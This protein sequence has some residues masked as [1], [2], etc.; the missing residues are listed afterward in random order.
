M[1]DDKGRFK[2]EDDLITMNLSL[3]SLTKI[4]FLSLFFVVFFP[5]IVIISKLEL[6][7]RIFSFFESV[8]TKAIGDPE[9]NKKNGLF[10]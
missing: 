1:R 5:W 2:K 3:P 10:Y 6:F 7:G 4:I 8:M 9:S